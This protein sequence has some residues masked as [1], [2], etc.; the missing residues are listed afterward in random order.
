MW[1][2]VVNPLGTSLPIEPDTAAPTLNPVE[3]LLLG[4]KDDQSFKPGT[5]IDVPKSEV[6][7]TSQKS[8][9]SVQTLHLPIMGEGTPRSSDASILNIMKVV[10]TAQATLEE[11]KFV[12]TLQSR[13]K[14]K[15]TLYKFQGFRAALE[16]ITTQGIGGN[17][18]YLGD[19]IRSRNGKQTT[20]FIVGVANL[21]LFLSKM[22]TDVISYERCDPHHIAC[23]IPALDTLFVDDDVVVKCASDP[24]DGIECPSNSGCTCVLGILNKFVGI[25][26]SGVPTEL[27]GADFCE[28]SLLK[29]VCSRRLSNGGTLRWLVPMAHWVLVVQQTEERDWNYLEELHAFVAGGMIDTGFVNRVGLTSASLAASTDRETRLGEFTSNFFGIIMTMSEALSSIP[30]LT[31]NGPTPPTNPLT[32]DPT[33]YYTRNPTGSDPVSSGSRSAEPSLDIKFDQLGESSGSESKQVSSQQDDLDVMWFDEGFSG[34]T[35][36]PASI[37]SVHSDLLSDNEAPPTKEATLDGGSDIVLTAS[38]TR[39]SADDPVSESD[40]NAT[41]EEYE[42]V[43]WLRREHSGFSYGG[44]VQFSTRHIFMGNLLVYHCFFNRII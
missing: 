5:N 38:P 22:I 37:P 7:E 30:K 28:T 42:W 32:K 4:G 12:I 18:F 43:S 31:T 40:E 19:V 20:N 26:S 14:I 2:P 39:S 23:G 33:A 44:E 1:I 16:Y 9:T 13:T 36:E 27:S 25:G 17:Y 11:D 34:F 15:S 8:E 41:G 29:S 21:A 24:E 3:P 35:Q 6:Q 10:D